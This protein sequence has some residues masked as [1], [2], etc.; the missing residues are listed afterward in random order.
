MNIEQI[1]Q[2]L[3]RIYDAAVAT[4][5]ADILAFAQQGTLPIA[6]PSGHGAIR[7]CASII[8]GAKPMPMRAVRLG[9]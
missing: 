5:R 1:I 3:A 7:N 9:G 2:D 8:R 6:L 4:L